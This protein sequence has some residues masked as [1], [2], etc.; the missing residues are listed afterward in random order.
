M[1]MVIQHIFLK[2]RVNL[3]TMLNRHSFADAGRQWWAIVQE[4]TARTHHHNTE[5][6]HYF[7]MR[8]FR[9]QRNSYLAF[10]SIFLLLYVG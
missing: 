1:F 10:F 2:G 8:L 4:R 9:A 6:D 7:H 5:A 3:C